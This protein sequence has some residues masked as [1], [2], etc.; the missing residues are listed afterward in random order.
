MP[1]PIVILAIALALTGLAGFGGTMYFRDQYHQCQLSI[2]EY[3]TEAEKKKAEAIAAAQAKSDEQIGKLTKVIADNAG[4][5]NTYTEKIVTVPVTRACADSESIRIG[6]SGLRAII[7]NAG[8]G[9][10]KAVSGPPTALP[11]TPAAAGKPNR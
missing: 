8:G 7:G 2:A 6:L 3:K 5:A 10:N 4:K 9:G 11:A 1:S